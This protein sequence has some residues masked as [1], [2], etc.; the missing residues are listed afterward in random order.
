MKDDRI[1]VL[2]PKRKTGVYRLDG[3]GG[4]VALAADPAFTREAIA[5][6]QVASH[7]FRNGLYLD[8]EQLNPVDR[9]ATAAP[10]QRP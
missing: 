2:E 4:Y 3:K 1:A 5:F 6:Y 10:V 8:E 7:V 9:V